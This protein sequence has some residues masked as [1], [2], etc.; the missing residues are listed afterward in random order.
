MP[1]PRGRFLPYSFSWLPPSISRAAFHAHKHCGPGVTRSSSRH[2]RPPRG[3][4]ADRRTAR[5]LQ[6]A[7]APPCSTRHDALHA[8]L[9][10]FSD[11]PLGGPPR[12]PPASHAPI[13]HHSAAQAP[14]PPRGEVRPA[15]PRPAPAR[16]PPRRN[17]PLVGD[18]RREWGAWMRLPPPRPPTHPPT[19]HPN[20]C[21]LRGRLVASSASSP[22]RLV[23]SK[24]ASL[25]SRL[26]PDADVSRRHGGFFPSPH[27]PQR[28][29]DMPP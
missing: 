27:R 24:A 20:L 2:E 14:P 18:R 26:V 8:R 10:T 15:M 11:P 6:V 9:G 7:I 22:R 5:P 28:G 17:S 19:P 4:H 16:R 13:P 29:V 3:V 25:R 23:A 1:L 12:S 21:G